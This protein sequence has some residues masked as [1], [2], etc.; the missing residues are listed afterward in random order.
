MVKAKVDFDAVD[1]KVLV[2]LA[3]HYARVS[4]RFSAE[5][6]MEAVQMEWEPL[7][8]ILWRFSRHELVNRELLIDGEWT[9]QP[10]LL[11]VADQLKHGPSPRDFSNELSAWFR[12]KWWSIP[13]L[14]LAV[15]VPAIFS[16]FSMLV[17]I[18]NW[19]G[20]GR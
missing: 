7:R 15:I 11:T 10:K 16:Y 14:V 8:R 3:E 2:A 6:L 4:P 18:I 12:S 19:S 1:K 5:E 13:L 20:G 9:I 17:S